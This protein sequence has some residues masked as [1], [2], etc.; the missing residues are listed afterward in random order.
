MA[1]PPQQ[2]GPGV[3]PPS[4]TPVILSIA[5][6]VCWY[7]FPPAAIMLGLIAQRQYRAQGRRETLAKVAW[8]GGIVV[9]VLLIL[10]VAL[11]HRTTHT[12]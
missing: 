10:L 8:I 4:R 1:P 5:G 9:F 11:S 2:P 3:Q 7:V 6:I 12:G